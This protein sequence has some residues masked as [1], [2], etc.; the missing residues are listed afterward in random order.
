M[1]A[2]LHGKLSTDPGTELDRLEDLLT[3]YV[4]GALKY[5]DRRCLAAVL[6]Q[7][8]PEV[9][10]EGSEVDRAALQFWPTFVDGT[11]PDV[12]VTI[13]SFCVVFE[14][15]LHS[16]FGRSRAQADHQ[17]I[18]EWRQSRRWVKARALRNAYVIAV[19]ADYSEPPDVGAANRFIEHQHG[20]PDAIRWISW[21][22][23][24]LLLE[25]LAAELKPSDQLMISDLIEVMEKR[26][27]RRVF[28]GF[29]QEDYWVVAAGTRIAAD[30]IFPA[31]A[32]FMQELYE[33]CADDQLVPG[34]PESKMVTSRSDS[35][36]KAH[37]WGTTHVNAPLWA[38]DWPKRKKAVNALLFVQFP[39]T[40][41][42][43]RVGFRIRINPKRKTQWHEH[44][45]LLCD[46]LRSSPTNYQVALMRYPDLETIV[47]QSDGSDIRAEWLHDAIEGG[48][49]FLAIQRSLPLDS[50]TQTSVVREMLL[51]D[52]EFIETDLRFVLDE[53]IEA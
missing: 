35:L 11:E 37:L 36:S 32:T 40:E 18:R 20:T 22:Q 4:F 46:V 15:K 48:E 3:D 14:A 28:N 45:D 42:M 1:H 8:I 9:D 16:S 25:S 43:I 44:V 38:R 13:G 30:R 27:V 34:T 21:Q 53:S 10:W 12:L 7:C 2:E 41:P 31:I 6:S 50:L 5:L 47:S 39:L 19:T 26:G 17:L 49:K 51:E 23:I 24:A 33:Q 52:R 29:N